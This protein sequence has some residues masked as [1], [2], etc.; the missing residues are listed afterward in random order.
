MRI[1]NFQ[2]TCDNNPIETASDRMAMNVACAELSLSLSSHFFPKLHFLVLSLPLYPEPEQQ[3]RRGIRYPCILSGYFPILNINRAAAPSSPSA[4][5][6]SRLPWIF[7]SN[8]ISGMATKSARQD[9]RRRRA[10][11][12]YIQSEPSIF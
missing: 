8:F 9:G 5:L 1:P 3:R 7:Q 2:R 12:M 10:G 4:L 11:S 6:P